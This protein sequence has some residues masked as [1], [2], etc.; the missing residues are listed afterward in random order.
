MAHAARGQAGVTVYGTICRLHRQRGPEVCCVFVC[1]C[2]P[3]WLPWS[4]HFTGYRNFN[5][6]KLKNVEFMAEFV[7]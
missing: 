2:V 3:E 4:C 7:M 1:E 6:K 5:G